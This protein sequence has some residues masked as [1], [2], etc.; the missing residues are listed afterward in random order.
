MVFTCFCP[1]DKDESSVPPIQTAPMPTYQPPS[2]TAD[3][4]NNQPMALQ[5]QQSFQNPHSNPHPFAPSTYGPGSVVPT[6]Q[7]SPDL[8]P[9]GQYPFAAQFSPPGPHLPRQYPSGQ[10]PFFSPYPP[11]GPYSPP[12]SYPPA[13]PY[14]V[15]GQIASGAPV[16]VMQ[17]PNRSG[18]GLGSVG[19]FAVGAAAGGLAGYAINSMV[20]S[21]DHGNNEENRSDTADHETTAT[22]KVEP[23]R[24]IDVIQEYPNRGG[25]YGEVESAYQQ[26][27]YPSEQTT[28]S[29]PP[30]AYQ[31]PS[32][33][34]G[35]F[36][37]DDISGDCVGEGDSV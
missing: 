15:T 37:G 28:H 22:A 34:S 10:Y 35:D 29:P 19:T 3:T 33:D 30:G 5:Q 27:T 11:A 13:A 23:Q 32:H 9:P 26:P 20:H 7:Y 31:E 16:P 18:G 21:V 36:G 12:G 25:M 17:Q 4:M 1:R 2:V 14:T 6:G 8:Y 24:D